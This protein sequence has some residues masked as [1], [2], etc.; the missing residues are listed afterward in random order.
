MVVLASISWV[1]SLLRSNAS[2]TA[3]IAGEQ[4]K[5]SDGCDDHLAFSNSDD[6]SAKYAI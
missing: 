6:A 1:R 2:C 4:L 3:S 5:T